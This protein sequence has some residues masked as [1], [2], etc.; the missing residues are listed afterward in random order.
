M[1]LSYLVPWPVGLQ[2]FQAVSPGA[3][4]ETKGWGAGGSLWEKILVLSWECGPY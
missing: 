2:V 3:A 1:K 4:A